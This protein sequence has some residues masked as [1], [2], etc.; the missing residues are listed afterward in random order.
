MMLVYQDGRGGDHRRPKPEEHFAYYRG[1]NGEND[2]ADDGKGHVERGQEIVIEIQLVGKMKQPRPDAQIFLSW[3][4]KRQIRRK[5]EKS[6]AAAENGKGHRDHQGSEFAAR[7]QD[8]WSH[9]EQQI[10]R[11]IEECHRWNEGNREFCRKMNR[12]PKAA[13]RGE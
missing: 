1:A 5:K 10:D 8:E 11:H 13:P 7:P 6:D 4:C 9:P 3:R 2:Y 12:D